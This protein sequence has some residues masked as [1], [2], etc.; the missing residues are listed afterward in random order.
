MRA[1]DCV[2]IVKGKYPY[3]F[4]QFSSS[5]IK[6]SNPI[7]LPGGLTITTCLGYDIADFLIIGYMRSVSLPS[8]YEDS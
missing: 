3:S 2:G 6:C 1:L 4:H 8:K 5:S 7:K